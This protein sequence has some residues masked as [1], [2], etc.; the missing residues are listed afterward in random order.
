MKKNLPITHQQL[1]YPKGKYIVSRTNLKGI[2]TYANDTFVE[3][4]G[5]TREE[6]IGKNH[7]IVRHPEMPSAAFEDLWNTVKASRPWRGLVKNRCKNGD[8]YWVEALVVPIRQNEQTIGYMSVRTE[9]SQS[10]I[11]DAEA[12]YRRINEGQAALPSPPWWRKISIST[13]LSMLVVFLILAQFAG[14]M[15]HEFGALIDLSDASIDRIHFTLD[16]LVVFSGI[17]LWWINRQ[18]FIATRQIIGRLDH[19]AQGDLSET[20]PLQR[21]DELGQLNDAVVTMQTHVKSMMS[22]I[23]EAA[24]FTSRRIDELTHQMEETQEVVSHQLDATGR[25]A[26]AVEQLVVSVDEM[27]QSAGESADAIQESR[28][29]ISHASGRMNDSRN[30]SKLV[31]STVNLASQ[32]MADLFKSIT[33]IS[34]ITRVINEISDQTNLLALNA[35]IEAARAGESGRGFAVVA[36]EVRKLAGKASK[37]TAEISASIQEIQRITQQAVSSMETTGSHVTATETAMD[38]VQSS[39]DQVTLQGNR[40]ASMSQAI[41]SGTREQ[42]QS[43]TEIACQVQD[44]VSGIDITTAA[45]AEVTEKAA[46]IKAAAVSLQHLIGYFRFIR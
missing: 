30:A 44:I 4:S 26:S 35:A 39:L 29:L 2:I 46:K 1:P 33:A 11:N 34:Q 45:I 14:D 22:E 41:A 27:A 12:L 20:I 31:V 6:L 25:I 24:N 3:I 10:Q 21:M 43:G 38:Q 13:Q 19:I 9:P 23:A 32:T 7:N 18:Y 28:G 15:V 37:Q 8:H 5:F 17:W 42:S 36:D 40:V 16:I